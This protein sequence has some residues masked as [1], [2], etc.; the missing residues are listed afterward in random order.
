MIVRLLLA[1]ILLLL[2]AV[3]SVEANGR[4]PSTSTITFR[5]GMDAEIVAGT[6]FGLVKSVDGGATWRW[7]CEDSIGYGGMYDPDY[8]YSATG[9]LFA[10]T[11]DGL[12]ANRDGCRFEMTP[13]GKRFVSTTALGPD[14]ALYFAAADSMDGK[15]YKS[16]DD[17]NTFPTSSMP[18]TTKDWW[19]SL[20]VAP[21]NPNRLYL[22]GYRVE[23]GLP[24]VFFLNR[25][26]NGGQTWIPLPVVDFAT[27]PN[28]TIEIAGISRT[29]PDRLYA[30]VTLEDNTISDAIYRSTNGGQNWTRVLGKPDSIAFLVRGTGELVAA[31]RAA[32]TFR[33]ADQ[34]AT[35]QPVPAAPHIN[36]LTESAAGEV[37]ACTQNY[38]NMQQPSDGAAIMKSVDLVAW[39]KVLRFQDIYEP[40]ACNAGTPQRDSCDAE[41]WC[42][43]C[44]QLGCDPQRSCPGFPSTDGP[45]AGGVGCC[46]TGGGG[47]AAGAF[48]LS[49]LVA[50][51]LSRSRRRS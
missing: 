6:T 35:W 49:A 46:E 38:A 16:T 51:V 25:S 18:G 43:L 50:F 7:V 21:S 32:G 9:T 13:S 23:I 24:K 33:S 28:S 44:A 20:E 45:P 27:M 11:F 40:V 26:D 19:Q 3:R 12:K 4:P 8:A 1:G 2:P 17:G 34:G 47:G 37:W 41:L 22:A 36:C 42:G 30:R 14:G 29:D 5:R 39:T 15:I 10:T 31:T 48:A